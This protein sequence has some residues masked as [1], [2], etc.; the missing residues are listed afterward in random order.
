[1]QGIAGFGNRCLA[2][3]LGQ[4]KFLVFGHH[5]AG[6]KILQGKVVPFG[7]G[8]EPVLVEHIFIHIGADAAKRVK[9]GFIQLFPVGKLNPQLE[10]GLGFFNKIF[11]VNVQRV[12][13]LQEWRNGG[14]TH[15]NGADIRR[16]HQLNRQLF[17][18]KLIAQHRRGNPPG[19]AAAH[20]GDFLQGVHNATSLGLS[21]GKHSA[22]NC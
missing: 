3:A 8:L 1:M 10:A 15:T 13:Q 7:A 20:D 18:G 17:G 6:G 11:L 14:F 19:G 16:L 22:I 4:E 2:C 21:A 5:R 9:V 12:Q